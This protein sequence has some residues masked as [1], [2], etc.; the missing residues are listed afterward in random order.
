M[1][2]GGGETDRI[3]PFAYGEPGYYTSPAW[4]PAGTRVAFHGRSK[5]EFQIMLADASRPGASVQQITAEGRN[6]DPSWAPDA[7]HIVFSGVRPGGSGLYV[8][9]VATGRVRPLL[10]G[11]R[12]RVPDWSPWLGGTGAVA[13]RR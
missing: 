8:I 10:S 11:G 9:D 4:A 7:R 5:G 13:A 3:S 12:Y 1:A 2:A 6:E